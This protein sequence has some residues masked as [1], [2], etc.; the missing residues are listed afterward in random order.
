MLHGM[1]LDGHAH[2]LA[3]R[4][5]GTVCAWGWNAHG[6]LGQGDNW[7]RFTPVQVVGLSGVVAIAA[8]VGGIS[9]GGPTAW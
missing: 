3:L 6:Q 8:G 4:D 5:N 1:L 9:W 2:S 7:D